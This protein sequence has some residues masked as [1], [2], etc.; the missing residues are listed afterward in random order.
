MSETCRGHLWEKIIVKLFA[1][2]WYIFLTYIYDA[3]SH[4]HQVKVYLEKKYERLLSGFTSHGQGRV[5]G[6]CTRGNETSGRTNGGEF[7]D[8]LC[9]CRL[10]MQDYRKGQCLAVSV[11]TCIWRCLIGILSWSSAIL[12]LFVVVLSPSAQMLIKSQCTFRNTFQFTIH[13]STI[14]STLHG[15]S[16]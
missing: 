3:R 13:Q 2:S 12:S 16:H 10:F 11:Q 5:K 6:F 4:L 9:G 7:R 15:R 8:Q 1:S 14:N